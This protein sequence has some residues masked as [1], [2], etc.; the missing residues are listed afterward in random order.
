M[1]FP[2]KIPKNK[3]PT[4]TKPVQDKLQNE[5]K[6]IHKIVSD[7][8]AKFFIENVTKLGLNIIPEYKFIENRKFRIDFFIEHNGKKLGFE[9]EGGVYKGGRH[10]SPKGFLRDMEKYNLFALNGIYLYRTIPDKLNSPQV[11]KDI[12]TFFGI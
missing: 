9:V 10:T 12:C 7:E 1:K 5:K 11:L 3:K 2:I 8:R 6:L 4:I